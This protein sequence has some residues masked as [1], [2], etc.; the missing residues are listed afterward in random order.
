QTNQRTKATRMDSEFWNNRYRESDRVWSGEPNPQLLAEADRLAPG[1]ALDAGCGEGA[2]AI[3]LARRGW[4]VTA[5]DFAQAAL[6]KGRAEAERQ[7]CAAAIDWVCQD[8]TG[9]QPDEEFDLVSA[10]FFHV[11]PSFRDKTV[12]HLANAVMAGG[13]LLV[14][15]HNREDLR[16]HAG[17][18]RHAETLF[19]PE[20]IERLL[21]EADWSIAVSEARQ[22]VVR[23]AEGQP[24][25]YTDTVVR[26]VRR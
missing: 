21:D 20:D 4:T 1:R 17:H 10:Q 5:V 24:F 16:T 6:D 25:N 18:E 13:S 2:D 15:G 7:G 26:A 8:L 9:W 11:E 14:V 23:T 19:D 12:R 3:W 22:R